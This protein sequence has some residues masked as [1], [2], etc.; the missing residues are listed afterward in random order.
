MRYSLDTNEEVDE[1]GDLTTSLIDIDRASRKR[2]STM[3]GRGTGNNLL[4][5]Q[6]SAEEIETK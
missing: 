1:T 3:A 2:N 4:D 5:N 6:E